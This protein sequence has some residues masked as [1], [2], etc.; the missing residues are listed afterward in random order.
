MEYL[1]KRETKWNDFATIW[2][3]TATKWNKFAKK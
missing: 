2:D 3:K 1:K